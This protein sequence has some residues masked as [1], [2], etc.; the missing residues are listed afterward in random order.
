LNKENKNKLEVSLKKIA[1]EWDFE[2][3]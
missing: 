1:N 3:F 2:I